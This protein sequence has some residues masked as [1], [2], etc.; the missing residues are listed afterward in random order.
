MNFSDPLTISAGDA[1]GLKPSRSFDLLIL[2]TSGDRKISAPSGVQGAPQPAKLP[3]CQTAQPPG[4]GSQ[5]GV[6]SAD[7][8]SAH[9][10]GP[11]AGTP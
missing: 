6:P 1:C 11:Q 3:H 2:R 4:P 9:C 10:R 8:P 5:A 7:G